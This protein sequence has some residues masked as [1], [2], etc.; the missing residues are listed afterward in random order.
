[1]LGPS[2]ASAPE[3]S[4]SASTKHVASL[5]C[6]SGALSAWLPDMQMLPAL[7]AEG[8]DLLK[9][10][11]KYDPKERITAAEAMRHP[12]LAD[13]ALEVP[14]RAAAGM[15]AAEGEEHSPLSDQIETRDVPDG[16]FSCLLQ[17]RHTP[18]VCLPMHGRRML[19]ACSFLV[20]SVESIS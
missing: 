11:L 20:H 15:H 2:S 5:L 8:V 6:C 3:L 14:E 19:L 10:L 4:L 18:S 1:M 9:C 16:G 17:D 13:A 7:D 12:W